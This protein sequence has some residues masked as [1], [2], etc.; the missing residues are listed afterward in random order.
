MGWGAA[1]LLPATSS[2]RRSSTR[3][4]GWRHAVSQCIRVRLSLDIQRGSTERDCV[5][6]LSGGRRAEEAQSWL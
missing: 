4:A 6:G 3:T 2:V 1:I 5:V